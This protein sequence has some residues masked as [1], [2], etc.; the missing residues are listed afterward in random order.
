MTIDKRPRVEL[1]CCNAAGEVVI[2]AKIWKGFKK[3]HSAVSLYV[4]RG[5][6][7]KSL[8]LIHRR[9]FEKSLYPYDQLLAARDTVAHLWAMEHGLS[10]FVVVYTDPK[11]SEMYH[12]S[13]LKQQEN[14]P[15]PSTN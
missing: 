5:V 8:R 1:F 11:M 2:L 13:E 12:P 3:T 6:Q 15:C 10:D 14:Q 7:S 4:V 9:G